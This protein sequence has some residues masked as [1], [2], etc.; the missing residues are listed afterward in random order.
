M[1]D[2][3]VHTISDL[4]ALRA[5]S[6]P[7]R[8]R[9]VRELRREPRT[10]AQVAAA[11]GE[12]PTKLHY[13]INELERNGLIVLVETR[14]KGNLLEKHYRAAAEYFRVDP[15]LFQG[16][17]EALQ[18]FQAN[19]AS[20]LDVT[21]VELQELISSGHITSEESAR[22]LRSLLRLQLTPAQVEEFRS[23]LEALV[24]EYRQKSAAGATA[25]AA[26]TLLFVP[27]ASPPGAASP[28]PE[29]VSGDSTSC[30]AD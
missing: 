4:G 12:A 26:L 19:V 22:S 1:S 17:P 9:I 13:H 23:R 25:G 27:L 30:A 7:L 3:R 6:D 11:L 28:A 20:I 21:A 14:Q 5:I 10:T 8:T 29:H 2:Q 24:E 16:G 15:A 18:A